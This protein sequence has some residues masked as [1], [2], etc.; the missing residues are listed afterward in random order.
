[1]FIFHFF[2]HQKA[3]F[4]CFQ[5]PK[6]E[7]CLDSN[8]FNNMT[9]LFPAFLFALANPCLESSWLLNIFFLF[10]GKIRST[11]HRRQGSAAI[12]AEN[13]TR[14]REKPTEIHSD[15]KRYHNA[16]VGWG[17][18]S[19]RYLW[20]SSISLPPAFKSL[21]VTQHHVV[22]SALFVAQLPSGGRRDVG[23]SQRGI[24]PQEPKCGG[25]PGDTDIASQ[26]KVG[27]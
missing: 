6:S 11:F 1:M 8:G 21:E 23:R 9:F 7:K 14:H 20:I 2:G 4:W 16:T 3:H 18:E 19:C 10:S 5:K 25:K 27:R 15:I 22:G 12:V 24:K 17:I 26:N 13:V